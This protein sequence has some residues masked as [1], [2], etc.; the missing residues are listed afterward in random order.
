[1]KILEDFVDDFIVML[2]PKSEEHLQP[3]SQA[4]LHGIQI[5]FQP[6]SVTTDAIP[7]PIWEADLEKGKVLWET[8]KE[9]L[10]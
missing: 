10:G 9:V 8:K 4:L 5:V 3:L 7:D 6:Q 2:Y 1:M